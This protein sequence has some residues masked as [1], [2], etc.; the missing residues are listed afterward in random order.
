MVLFIITFFTSIFAILPNACIMKSTYVIR[1]IFFCQYF[2]NFSNRN[3][4]INFILKPLN[5]QIKNNFKSFRNVAFETNMQPNF[6]P[7]QLH[8]I[9]AKNIL[10]LYVLFNN[11]LDSLSAHTQ[12]WLTKKRLMGSFT[13][14]LVSTFMNS[15]PVV[16]N[17]PHIC[18]LSCIIKGMGGA[19]GAIA[20]PLSNFCQGKIC[21][22]PGRKF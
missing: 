20:P 7:L 5:I 17:S 15:W 12:L 18:A 4:V 13:Y 3:C 10:L 2:G 11:S 6:L 1:L 9:Q 14:R 22:H 16:R 8:I 19:E 21:M